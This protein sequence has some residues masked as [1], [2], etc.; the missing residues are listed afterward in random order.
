ML[1]VFAELEETTR[2]LNGHGLGLTFP[3]PSMITKHLTP[4]S[5]SGELVKDRDG[6]RRALAAARRA[7]EKSSERG[8]PYVKYWIGRLEFGIGY[9]DC[10]E[11]AKHLGNA[12]SELKLAREK[13]DKRM[14]SAKRREALVHAKAALQISSKMLNTLASVARNQSDRG[15]IAVMSEYIYRPLQEQVRQ[16]RK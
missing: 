14:V 15:A 4:G 5:L 10:I 13:A 16:L 7:V 1:T 8:R 12:N 2:H 6:Y 3:V 11:A 9:I